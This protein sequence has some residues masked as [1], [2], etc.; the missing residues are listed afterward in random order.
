MQPYNANN[1]TKPLPRATF[2]VILPLTPK[3]PDASI[4][5]LSINTT[6]NKDGAKKNKEKC[7]E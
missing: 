3:Y 4:P 6:T 5:K 2:L 1:K 7:W